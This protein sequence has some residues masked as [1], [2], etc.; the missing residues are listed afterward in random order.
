MNTI[1]VLGQKGADY[2]HCG[3]EGTYEDASNVIS[4]AF[5]PA[6]NKGTLYA[7]WEV[8]AG[9]TWVPSCC[10]TYVKMDLEAWWG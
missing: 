5:A 8:G 3:G 6:V 10:S 1:A 9:E 4:T 2:W 7:A